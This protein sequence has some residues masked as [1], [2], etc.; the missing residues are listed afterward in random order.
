MENFYVFS[1]DFRLYQAFHVLA[2]NAGFI[3]ND[4]FTLFTEESA[5]KFPVVCFSEKFKNRVG[6]PAFAF[7]S[8]IG[9][10]PKELEFSLDTDFS[11]ALAHMIDSRPKK[12]TVT[13]AEIAEW[14][15]CKIE[16]LTII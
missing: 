15:Q 9:R 1:S 10:N 7:S 3:S 2:T 12:V 8:N 4:A 11:A 6:V 13:K 14:K 5:A 16:N